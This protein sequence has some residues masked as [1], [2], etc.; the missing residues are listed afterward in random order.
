MHEPT[1]TR[2][3][4]ADIDCWYWLK[5]LQKSGMRHLQVLKIKSKFVYVKEFRTSGIEKNSLITRLI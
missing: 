3:L 4:D 2:L 1:I 5:G